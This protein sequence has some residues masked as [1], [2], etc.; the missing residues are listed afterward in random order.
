M[1]SLDETQKEMVGYL[2]LIHCPQRFYKT[3]VIKQEVINL[4]KKNQFIFRFTNFNTDIIDLDIDTVQLIKI[5]LKLSIAMYGSFFYHD[6]KRTFY[7][8]LFDKVNKRF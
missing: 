4:K 3:W 8:F 7:F 6:D 5:Q 2:P 1:E